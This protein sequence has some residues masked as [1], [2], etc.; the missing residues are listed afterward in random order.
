MTSYEIG[1][2]Q[3]WQKYGAELDIKLFHEALRDEGFGIALAEAMA[4]RLPIVATDVGACREVLEAGRCGLLVPEQDPQAMAACEAIYGERSDMQYCVSKEAALEGADCLVI[5]T[6]W[7]TF[8]S[9]DFA[10]IKEKLTRPLIVDGRNLYN[11]A[12]MAELGIEYYGIGR[13]L[14]I[15]QPQ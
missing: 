15:Q 3:N 14:S 5:C 6:E 2:V 1:Y 4:A 12:H 10:L 13:G 9:P 11:P 7:K 8:W